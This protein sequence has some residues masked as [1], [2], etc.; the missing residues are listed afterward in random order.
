MRNWAF[1]TLV[2]VAAIAGTAFA[3][4]RAGGGCQHAGGVHPGLHGFAAGA[5]GAHECFAERFGVGFALSGPGVCIRYRPPRFFFDGF[6]GL[7]GWAA[8]GCCHGWHGRWCGGFWFGFGHTC[9][10]VVVTQSFY[11]GAPVD[12]WLLLGPGCYWPAVCSPFGWWGTW[13]VFLPWDDP[14]G[15]VQ[16][17]RVPVVGRAPRVRP[18]R[19]PVVA[20]NVPDPVLRVPHGRRPQALMQRAP[21]GSGRIGRDPTTRV[22]ETN[23]FKSLLVRSHARARQRH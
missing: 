15:A 8:S 3:Q 12:G 5:V 18:L 11:F 6:C 16:A 17:R 13:P 20:R 2:I 9:H 19:V 21:V 10:S 14:I 23:L 7:P 4:G 1:C 22:A